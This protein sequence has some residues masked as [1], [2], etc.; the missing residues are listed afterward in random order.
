M[1]GNTPPP[2]LCRV[3]PAGAA[4]AETLSQLHAP[5]QRRQMQG[6]ATI[7]TNTS[8]SMSSV[9]FGTLLRL[10]PCDEGFSGC[11]FCLLGETLAAW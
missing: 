11:G 1:H 6:V 2:P 9:R 5:Q 10:G 8:T 4:L 3:P 7:R